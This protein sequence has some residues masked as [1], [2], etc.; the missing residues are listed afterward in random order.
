MSI[1]A[2]SVVIG[3]SDLF[4]A[5]TRI[6][7]YVV[8]T[9]LTHSR[10]LSS[11][12]GCE[13][14]LKQENRQC[15]GSFKVRGA[16]NKLVSL[17]RQERARGV[18]AAS[19]GNHAIA[20]AYASRILAISP[21]ELFVEESADKSKLAKLD[22][23]S[24]KVHVVPGTFEDAKQAALTMAQHTGAVFVS[25]YDDALIIAGQGTCGLEIAEDLPDLDAVVV[26]VGGGGLISG[27]CVAIKS[28]NSRARVVGVNPTASPSA[29]LSLQRGQAIDPYD[30]APTLAGPL[31]GG[32]GKIPYAVAHQLIDSVVLVTED[33]LKQAIAALIDTEQILAEPAGAAGVAAAISRK[34]KTAQKVAIVISGGNIDSRSLTSILVSLRS[35]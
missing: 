20:I 9:P 6:A 5:R 33:E 32:F 8:R 28:T 25:P 24:V 26:P 21:V 11:R 19:A 31:A 13:V 1:S 16:M 14:W 7:P 3:L 29:L 4:V 12:S 23:Y 15:T 30:A 17:T 35:S 27:I 34:L 22:E 18:V 2:D 10:L